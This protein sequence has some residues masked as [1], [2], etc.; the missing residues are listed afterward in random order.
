MTKENSPLKP[1]S[2]LWGYWDWMVNSMA[3]FRSVE[4]PALVTLLSLIHI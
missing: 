1:E 4:I 3:I 2:R